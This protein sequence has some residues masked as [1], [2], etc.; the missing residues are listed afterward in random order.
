MFY[1][2]SA[3]RTI[4]Q[5]PKCFS[6]SGAGFH[7]TG[8]L[9][10]HILWVVCLQQR[11]PRHFLSVP[12]C[13]EPV[14]PLPQ[15]CAPCTCS[16]GGHTAR[17]SVRRAC[18]SP[19]SLVTWSERVGALGPQLALTHDGGGGSVTRSGDRSPRCAVTIETP[20]ATLVFRAGFS[21][22][23]LQFFFKHLFLLERA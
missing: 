2:P 9:F 15:P 1:L 7:A 23:I 19:A 11:S 22:Q 8:M 14:S 10:S 3:P 17:A 5:F 4:R 18:R 6:V 21:L 16:P 20:A 13:V 12:G